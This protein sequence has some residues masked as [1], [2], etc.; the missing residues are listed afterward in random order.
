MGLQPQ[1]RLETHCAS[2]DDRFLFS[3]YVMAHWKAHRLR[4]SE[5]DPEQQKVLEAVVEVEVL[6]LVR[7][8]IEHGDFPSFQAQG[9]K[10]VKGVR[11]EVSHLA[12]A[13][14]VAVISSLA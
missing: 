4:L 11:V 7:S 8:G 9:V 1:H 6:T 14:V 2:R 3:Q 5:P 12:V 13:E 10:G